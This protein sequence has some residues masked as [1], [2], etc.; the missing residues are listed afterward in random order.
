[1][2]ASRIFRDSTLD[3]QFWD[4]GG[5]VLDFVSAAELEE[6]R[7]AVA[8]LRPADRWDPSTLEHPRGTYHCTFLD[9]DLEYRAAANDLVR[10]AFGDKLRQLLPDYRI[11]TANVYS[12]PPGTGRFE[13]HQNWPT[14]PDM[15]VPTLTAWIPL[16]DTDFRNGTLRSVHGSHRVFPDVAAASSSNFFDDFESTLIESY[17]EPMS[18]KAG[19]VYAFDDSLIHWSGPNLS[20]EPRVSFQIE[21]IPDGEQ[22]VMWVLNPDDPNQFLQWAVDSDFFLTRGIEDLYGRPRDL[23]LL[24]ST[25]NPNKKITLSEFRTSMASARAIRDAKYV[26]GVD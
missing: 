1:M 9:P 12:K 16:Q 3:E 2:I 4:T 11:L 6:V 24:A 20:S 10:L 18:L 7:A 17:L 14:L 22:A 19:Q 23:R 8:K 21:L 5:A 26:F 13:V 25:P 15:D